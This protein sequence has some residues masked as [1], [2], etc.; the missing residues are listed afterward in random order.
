MELKKNEIQTLKYLFYY[1]ILSVIFMG[2][3]VLAAVFGIYANFLKH[4]TNEQFYMNNALIGA[5]L[6]VL[7]ISY[8]VFY[9][10]HLI[11]KLKSLLESAELLK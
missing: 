10:I 4:P 6:V 1:K 3:G 2:L 8:V 9:L 7:G 11:E 5:A